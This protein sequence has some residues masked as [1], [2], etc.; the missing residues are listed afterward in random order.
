MMNSPVGDLF[1]PIFLLRCGGSG[2]GQSGAGSGAG[3]GAG[4]AGAGS[5]GGGSAEW[6]LSAAS[7]RCA[8]A[9]P[10]AWAKGNVEV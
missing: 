3:A 4:C 8:S 9:A 10:S 2:E 1:L 7:Q 6:R 5:A